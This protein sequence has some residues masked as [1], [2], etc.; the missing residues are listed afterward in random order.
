[1]QGKMK[2]LEMQQW[3]AT[4]IVIL[5]K[6]YYFKLLEKYCKSNKNS[7]KRAGKEYFLAPE[8]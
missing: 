7:G 8:Q 2:W 4:A 5:W 3:T 6:W 1:M